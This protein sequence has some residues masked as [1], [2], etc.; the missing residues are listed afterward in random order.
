VDQRSLT[1][2]A[3]VVLLG[4]PAAADH[5]ESMA[6][7]VFEI[8]GHTI[9]AAEGPIAADEV[10]SLE[11]A[12]RI[13]GSIDE[14]WLN[15]GGGNAWEGLDMGRLVRAR[16][17]ATRVPRGA[18]CASACVFV[19]LGGV[20]RQVDEEGSIGVHMFSRSRVKKIVEHYAKRLEEAENQ[21]ET[22][23]NIIMEIEQSS[24]RFAAEQARFLVE[25]SVS[26]EIMIPNFETPFDD[27]HDMSRRELRRY[28][29]VNVD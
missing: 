17:I 2:L 26:L 24:A 21:D 6:Y 20:I 25:M 14:L 9:L 16:G 11:R 10:D 28:N 8:G 12:L 7:E 3:L 15:S 22:I 13:A 27:I 19:F 4:G 1:A 29:V 5:D 18:Y 23:R